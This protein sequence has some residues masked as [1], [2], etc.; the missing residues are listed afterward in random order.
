MSAL[1][2]ATR[3]AVAHSLAVLFAKD[4]QGDELRGAVRDLGWQEIVDED[5]TAQRLLFAAQGA[6]L[7]SSP[8]LD[9]VVLGAFPDELGDG[10][11]LGRR[12]LFMQSDQDSGSSD[13]VA[14]GLFL[15]PLEGATEVAVLRW[16]G[17]APRAWLV[18]ASDV[19][20]AVAITNFD[21]SS[22]TGASA[23]LLE[24]RELSTAGAGLAVAAA[25]RALAAEINAVSAGALQMAIDHTT[26]RY[27]YG[28]PLASFQSV[29]HSLAEAHAAIEASNVTL[30]VAYDV[31]LTRADSAL[32]ASIAKLRAGD[33][34][35]IVLRRTVQVLGA[36][37]LTLESDMHRYVTRAAALDALLGSHVEIAEQIAG[38]LLDGTPIRRVVSVSD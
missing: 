13:A 21:R 1:D 27:Q 24:A 19:T 12:V 32:M 16:F 14:T 33:T 10:D 37:G 34:Q 38:E 20:A 15:A 3:T 9:D 7:A 6:A 36:M 26:A 28:R 18:P 11:N 8:V 31:E 29:R 4:L 23:N 35:A 22:W 17:A 2:D 25:R 5:P 30:D